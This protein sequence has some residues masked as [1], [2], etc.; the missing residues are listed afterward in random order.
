MEGGNEP[1][2]PVKQKPP[3]GWFTGAVFGRFSRT[4]ICLRIVV[5]FLFLVLQG[6]YHYWTFFV[7]ES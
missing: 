4:S 2:G 5:S 3:V 1:G 7:Q 6:I